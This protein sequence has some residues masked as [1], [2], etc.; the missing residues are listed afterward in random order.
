MHLGFYLCISFMDLLDL[1]D[2]DPWNFSL[3]K[4]D[5]VASPT[6][7]HL[8][9]NEFSVSYVSKGKTSLFSHCNLEPESKYFNT[10]GF[11]GT[12]FYII[13]MK[14]KKPPK[15]KSVRG[16]SVGTGQSRSSGETNFSLYFSFLLLLSLGQKETGDKCSIFHLGSELKILQIGRGKK[17]WGQQ[18]SL[19]WQTNQIPI[20]S[21][22]FPK[23]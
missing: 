4:I 22:S 1:K 12:V 21:V 20:A 3:A 15:R 5:L 18:F 2:E 17:Q 6:R 7:S 14:R 19:T 23:L 13:R 11:Q 16:Q 10:N 9:M 8:L